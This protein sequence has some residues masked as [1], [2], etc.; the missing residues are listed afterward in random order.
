MFIPVGKLTPAHSAGPPTVRGLWVCPGRWEGAE[1]TT[2]GPPTAQGIIYCPWAVGERPQQVTWPPTAQGT[3][4]CP[5]AVGEPPQQIT[6]LFH[7]PGTVN[8][9]LGGGWTCCSELRTL[10]QGPGHTHSPRTV[11]GPALGAGVNF[12]GVSNLHLRISV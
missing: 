2:A 1:F 4:Y 9:D 12:P 8:R 3:I 11:G 7:C 5:W 10:P 6:W